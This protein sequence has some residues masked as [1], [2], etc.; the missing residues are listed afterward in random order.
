MA[1]EA[2]LGDQMLFIGFCRVCETGPLG[3]RTCGGCNSVLVVCDECD[4]LWT[5]ADTSQPPATTGS[6]TLACPHCEANLYD[7]PS[8]WSTLDDAAN[9]SWVQTALHADQFSLEVG[10]PLSPPDV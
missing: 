2:D 8:H 5:D 10:K 1:D 4:S 7:A 9:S 3:L 6:E